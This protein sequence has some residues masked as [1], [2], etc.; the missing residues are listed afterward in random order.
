MFNAPNF[1]KAWSFWAALFLAGANA[2]LGF[3]PQLESLMTPESFA[4]LNTFGGIVIAL[5]RSAAQ[6]F[7]D[8]QK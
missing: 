6:T 8:E 5:L 3:L 4:A 7:P 2:A 1:M